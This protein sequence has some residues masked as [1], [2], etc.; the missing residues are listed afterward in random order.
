MES[1]SRRHMAGLGVYLDE[2][3]DLHVAEAL[4]RRGYDAA[5]AL[6]EGNVSMADAE[7]LRYATR[8]GRAVV[9]HN[10]ADFAML[11]VDFLQRSEAHEGIVLVPWRPRSE[12]VTR[13]GKHLDGT[14]ASVQRNNLL[15][16]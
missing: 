9:T 16:A 11:H 1:G 13:I 15:W 4:R 12:L 8:Q 6:T 5:H 14:T 10:F 7:H 3:V 2:N